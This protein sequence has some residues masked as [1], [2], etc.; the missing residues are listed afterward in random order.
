MDREPIRGPQELFVG[1]SLK[2]L[3]LDY[4]CA[5]AGKGTEYSSSSP[6]NACQPFWDLFEKIEI[7][8]EVFPARDE[9]IIRR[10]NRGVCPDF[11]SVVAIFLHIN[12]C[13]SWLSGRVWLTLQ[14]GLLWNWRADWV[15]SSVENSRRK[16]CW[17]PRFVFERMQK[18][19]LAGALNIV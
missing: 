9:R 14:S 3:G 13:I 11:L 19:I 10:Y 7:S 8:F 18:E 12:C 15:N 5:F 16:I 2:F 4:W 1:S 6:T 17:Q